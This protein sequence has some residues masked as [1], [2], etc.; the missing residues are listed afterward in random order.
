MSAAQTLT[1]TNTGTTPL[2]LSSLAANGDFAL[3]SGTN[4]AIGSSLPAGAHCL[5]N[6]TFTPTTKGSRSGNITVKDNALAQEQVI[7][8]QGT[9]I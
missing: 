8:L 1:L 4:C 7:L 9:G 6:V 2:V 3:A 5:I